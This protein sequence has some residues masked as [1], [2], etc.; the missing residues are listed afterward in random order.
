MLNACINW[1]PFNTI[2]VM[3]QKLAAD[4]NFY[5]YCTIHVRKFQ[6]FAQL[7]FKSVTF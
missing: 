4:L 2:Y 3:I 7:K 1:L 5:S 6:S